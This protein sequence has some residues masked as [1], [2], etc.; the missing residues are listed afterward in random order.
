MVN[1]YKKNF[2]KTPM[3]GL[4]LTLE[5]EKKEIWFFTSL[6]S[7]PPCPVSININVTFDEDL[8]LSTI[9]LKWSQVIN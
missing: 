9:S 3:K 6:A 7:S 4:I 1:K 2:R 8:Q 5:K